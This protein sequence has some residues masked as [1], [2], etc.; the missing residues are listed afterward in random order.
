MRKVLTGATNRALAYVALGSLAVI[1]GLQAVIFGI[2]GSEGDPH[3]AVVAVAFV[4]FWG[5]VLTL[6]VVAIMAARRL[7]A[8]RRQS[9]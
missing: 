7:R 1:L 6:L 5:S 2:W 4:L 8:S 3:D 9:N